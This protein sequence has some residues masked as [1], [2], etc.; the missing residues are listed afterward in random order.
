MK[1]FRT[2]VVTGAIAVSFLGVFSGVLFAQPS[3]DTCPGN[4]TLNAYT[5]GATYH[6]ESGCRDVAGVQSRTVIC[7]QDDYVVRSDTECRGGEPDPECPGSDNGD[8]NDFVCALNDFIRCYDTHFVEGCIEGFD[9]NEEW[10]YRIVQCYP[11]D[12]PPPAWQPIPCSITNQSCPTN[13]GVTCINNFCGYI[14]TSPRVDTNGFTCQLNASGAEWTKRYQSPTGGITQG[15]ATAV[16]G[17]GNVYVAGEV[18]DITTGDFDAF[19]AK[20][21]PN[22]TPYSSFGQQ[23]V[24]RYDRSGNNDMAYGIAIDSAGNIYIAGKTS[25]VGGSPNRLLLIKFG[26]DGALTGAFNAQDP[27][28]LNSTGRGI[29]VANGNVYVAGDRGNIAALWVFDQTTGVLIAGQYGPGATSAALS[30]AADSSGVYTTG[31]QSTN[32]GDMF[33]RGFSTSGALRWTSGYDVASEASVTDSATTRLSGSLGSFGGFCNA[34]TNAMNTS[35]FVAPYDGSVRVTVDLDG[36]DS[37]DGIRL[38]LQ[39]SVSGS[40]FGFLGSTVDCSSIMC[41]PDQNNDPPTSI[42]LTTNSSVSAGTRVTLAASAFEDRDGGDTDCQAWGDPAY[43]YN[44]NVNDISNKRWE[45]LP[46]PQISEIGKGIAISQDGQTVFVTGYQSTNGGDASLNAYRSSNGES[47]WVK[48]YNSDGINSDTGRGVAAGSEGR[49]YVTGSQATTNGDVFM[50]EYFSGDYDGLLQAAIAPM[51]S[52]EES[53]FGVAVNNSGEVY[54]AGFENTNNGQAFVSKYSCS[55]AAS[56]SGASNGVFTVLPGYTVLAGTTV[57]VDASQSSAGIVSFAWNWDD[58]GATDSGVQSSH[59]Y[60]TPGPYTILLTTT[61]NTGQTQVT[62]QDIEVVPN[63]APT[64]AFVPTPA[65]GVAPLTVRVDGAGSGAG[66]N[67]TEDFGDTI[68]FSWDWGDDTASSYGR[69]S[70]HTY[71]TTGT[72]TITLTVTDM[73][74]LAAVATF[75]VDATNRYVCTTG[76]GP[77]GAC[78]GA[79]PVCGPSDT[80]PGATQCYG[81]MT[82]AQCGVGYSCAG[83]N[84]KTGELCPGVNDSGSYLCPADGRCMNA[85]SIKNQCVPSSSTL[86]TQCYVEAVGACMQSSDC[87]ASVQGGVCDLEDSTSVTYQQCKYARCLNESPIPCD[88]D[89]DCAQGDGICYNNLCDFVYDCAYGPGLG[90]VVRPYLTE[91]PPPPPAMPVGVQPNGEACTQPTPTAPNNCEGLNGC[92]YYNYQTIKGDKCSADVACLPGWTC[93][94]DGFCYIGLSLPATANNPVG[95]SVAN[96]IN[97]YQGGTGCV[98]YGSLSDPDPTHSKVNCLPRATN[99]TNKK[100]NAANAGIPAGCIVVDK[101]NSVKEYNCSGINGCYY[102]ADGKIDCT[103]T[104]TITSGPGCIYEPNPAGAIVC[105]GSTQPITA[106]DNFVQCLLNPDALLPGFL[107]ASSTAGLLPCGTSADCPLDQNGSQMICVGGTCFSQC[108]NDVNCASGLQCIVSQCPSG[109][110][111]NPTLDLCE[112]GSC[113]TTFDCPT[114]QYTC[115]AT[116]STGQPCCTIPPCPSGTTWN[117]ATQQ[118]E[119]TSCVPGTICPDGQMCPANGICPDPIP[120]CTGATPTGTLP[121]G[122]TQTN[123]GMTTT[124]DSFCRYTTLI[125][126]LAEPFTFT[127]LTLFSPTG[128][129]SHFSPVVGLFTLPSINAYF[130]KCQAVAPPQT[131]TPRACQIQFGVGACTPG[132]R[133]PDGQMCPAN[134][135]CPPTAICAGAMVNNIAV[136][137]TPALS[138]GMQTAAIGMTTTLAANCVY[139]AIP[140]ES[141][142][143]MTPFAATG[144]TSHSA[145][146]GSPAPAQPLATGNNTQ[147][148][149]C[150]DVGTQEETYCRIPFS[151]G[152][153]N[154]EY[155]C[156][157]GW[158]CVPN[159]GNGI[160]IPLMC[161]P[162]SP[163]Y[164]PA[165]QTCSNVWC[166]PSDPRYDPATQTCPIVRCSIGTWY[167]SGTGACVNCSSVPAPA[168]CGPDNRI[169]IINPALCQTHGDPFGVTPGELTC[170]TLG[171]EFHGTAVTPLGNCDLVAIILAI[172]SWLAWIVAL[173]AVFSGLRAAYLYIT[174]AGDEKKLRDARAYLIYTTVGVGVAILSFSIV[175]ITRALMN[176]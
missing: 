68:S 156:S 56:G 85:N 157:N 139:S 108:E 140:T 92:L 55:A 119:T 154:Q 30:V 153:C 9:I 152:M 32:N 93:Q 69:V 123:I 107:A 65:I 167:D 48:T 64:A 174:S 146:V 124:E 155:Q 75:A 60:N 62:P 127:N 159:T 158:Q 165:T 128:G 112:D 121:M 161:T 160:C 54:V 149:R 148:V 38:K 22:G 1:V 125:T 97:E 144:G 50:H 86:P 40:G 44:S 151:V 21:N 100:G 90:G 7:Y 105:P 78:A 172:L 33:V 118:C 74:G 109:T 132:T 173:L 83:T 89:L 8:R 101:G 25:S 16:D 81:C 134:G 141:F 73:G 117:Q 98:Y 24:V 163:G 147:Y 63:T 20:Y 175:A 150:R 102:Y 131:I 49:V 23:G 79:T 39:C 2:I 36:A 143:Q 99:E 91:A 138:T 31:Y 70:A 12:P 76:T 115:S 137:P 58:A 88:S 15:Y 43:C 17:A 133:C 10:D 41:G 169:C 176:I 71:T 110:T 136:P 142:A 11:N 113:T 126:D 95:N 104:D 170:N 57:Y 19:V 3:P 164:D 166:D 168:V 114:Q 26:P 135:I 103:Y 29:A 171:Y 28:G 66:G 13:P 53:G 82:D 96:C 120:A 42:T 84:C 162:L 14:P 5:C 67:D 77:G 47:T 45:I 4:D 34:W 51:L 18:F 129:M 61:D 145:T 52:T 116:C 94:N 27:G 80:T 111:Y 37:T 87:T 6:N 72:Y 122:T 46:S 106:G 59:R 130:V 35:S